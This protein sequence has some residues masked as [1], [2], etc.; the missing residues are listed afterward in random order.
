MNS[1]DSFCRVKGGRG[2]SRGKEVT[3]RMGREGKEVKKRG[4]LSSE[5]KR[6]R[7]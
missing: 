1:W 6:K 4:I 7:L 5:S 3:N 2:V